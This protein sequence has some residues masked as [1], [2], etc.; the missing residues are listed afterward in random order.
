M[1]ADP[2]D[3]VRALSAPVCFLLLAVALGIGL[4]IRMVD[5]GI[6]YGSSVLFGATCGVLGAWLVGVL[7]Q[8][9][10]CVFWRFTRGYPF[11]AGDVVEVT[12][13]PRR[14]SLGS[15]VSVGQAPWDLEVALQGE[16]GTQWFSAGQVRASKKGKY[17]GE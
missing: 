1:S 7:Y 14:G 11:V 9:L 12:R 13:G 3:R 4:A 16:E 10:R 2:C 6:G 17:G 8:S 5:R 15:V